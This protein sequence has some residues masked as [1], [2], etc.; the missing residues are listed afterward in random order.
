MKSISPR[1]AETRA[2]AC[3]SSIVSRIEIAPS[4]CALA[5]SARRP[6]K[7]HL[8]G[9]LFQ[10]CPGE[11]ILG[12]LE[13]L[14]EV[15]LSPFRHRERSGPFPGSRRHLPRHG[16]HVSGV[17]RARSQLVGLQVM[18]GDD[19]DDLVLVGSP[20]LEEIAGDREMLVLAVALGKRLVRDRSHEVLEERVLA[21]VRGPRI[22]SGA[23]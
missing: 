20:R 22:G 2:L 21:T 3:V 23:R 7:C 16:L 19:F 1:R 18:G 10:G 8:S 6:Q 13:R 9:A 5:W 4:K 11:Q 12:E 14:L 17:G 15:V